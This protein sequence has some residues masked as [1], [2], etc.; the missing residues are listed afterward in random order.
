[1]FQ[2]GW[3]MNLFYECTRSTGVCFKLRCK[4]NYFLPAFGNGQ[5]TKLVALSKLN[6]HSRFYIKVTQATHFYFT[7]KSNI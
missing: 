3:K 1:M 4:R 7:P 2:S 6:G 5:L